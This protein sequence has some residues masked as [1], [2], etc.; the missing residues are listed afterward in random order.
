MK[1][2]SF[3]AEEQANNS[4]WTISEMC[5]VLEVSRSGFYD[6]H[7]R[8]PSDRELSD[9]G[10]AIE[11]EAIWECSDRTYGAPRVHRWLCK[12]GFVVGH[13]RWRGSWRPTARKARP[14]GARSARR[15][16]TEAPPQLPIGSNATSTRRRQTRSGAATSPTCA[17][18]KGGSTW[19][20]SS[21]CTREG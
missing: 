18:V 6:W 13:N 17:P 21:T 8:G 3:I 11:I 14:G 10:L 12:Q 2:Y 1:I 16:S 15:S 7:G 19:R 4:I 20:P 5:R 9:R